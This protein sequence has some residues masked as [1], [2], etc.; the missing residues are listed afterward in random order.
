MFV[1]PLAL[2]I[3]T[4]VMIFAQST[5][6]LRESMREQRTYKVV[7]K[8][9]GEHIHEVVVSIKKKNIDVLERKLL[10]E[11]TEPGHSQYQNW[12]TFGTR[13][14]RTDMFVFRGLLLF[15]HIY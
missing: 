3:L 9:S 13:Y 15:F 11:L 6:V 12:L 7:G 1:F 2:V 10:D 8:P 4:S 5:F 14:Q